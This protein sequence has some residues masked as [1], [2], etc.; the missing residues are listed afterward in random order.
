MLIFVIQ[1]VDFLSV[2]TDIIMNSIL[3]NGM[4]HTKRLSA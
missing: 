3:Q 4:Q 2:G 1:G